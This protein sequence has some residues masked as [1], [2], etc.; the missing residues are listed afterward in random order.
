MPEKRGVMKKEIAVAVL[1]VLGF[2]ISAAISSFACTDFIIKAKDGAVIEGRSTENE[3][4][5]PCNVTFVPRGMPMA[6]D[7]PNGKPGLKWVT[8][9]AFIGIGMPKQNTYL[10]SLNEAGLSVSGLW[11][12][13]E[14]QN[15][16]ETD[17]DKAIGSMRI[18]SWLLSSFANV[19]E[20]K[21][22]ITQVYVW[23]EPFGPIKM[24]MLL[25]IAVHD[26]SG[27]SIV[28]EYVKGELNLYDNPVVVMTNNP[29]FDWHLNNLARYANLHPE[30]PSSLNFSGTELSYPC[31]GSGFFGIPGEATS[32][33]RFVRAA[34]YSKY[35]DAPET[36]DKGAILAAHIL[37]AVDIPIGIS[38]TPASVP[39]ETMHGSVYRDYTLWVVI[40]DL[41]NKVL[42]YRT[43]NDLTLRKVDLM[44]LKPEKEKNIRSFPLYGYENPFVDMTDS[45]K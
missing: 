4:D 20:V 40:K 10:D 2:V 8:K 31:D 11:F 42:Y 1:F 32:P 5:I 12:D 38:R 34:L 37:N 9:Y 41:K 3:F 45:M 35:S 29:G 28:I 15:I 27:K 23:G 22:N 36:A 6:A 14:Y 24:V 17:Y 25:H 39:T 16:S 7:A 43:Y 18:Y 33:S 21:K 13:G 19:D 44:K 30:S 26:A